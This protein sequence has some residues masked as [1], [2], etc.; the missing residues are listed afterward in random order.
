[1]ANIEPFESFTESYDNW[2]DE[3]DL[4]YKEELEA[5]KKLMPTFEKGVEIGVGTG[6][7]AAPLG[8]KTGVEPSSK[9]GQIAK[10]RG[11]N[12]VKGTAESIPFD[13]ESFDLVLIVTTICFV[14]DAPKALKEIYRILKPG[15]YVLVGFVDKEAPLGRRYLEKKDESKFYKTA[16]FFSAKDVLELLEKSGFSE[17]KAVQT[18]YGEDL[19]SMKTG[20]KYGYGEGAFVA[21]RCKK[22]KL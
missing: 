10:K 19:D 15:G 11:V 5:L 22:P 16:T 9:M 3:H 14:D 4:L 6:R 17:C 8:I 2:F 21:I 18:L 12:V 20:L 1:M 13:K 7:F